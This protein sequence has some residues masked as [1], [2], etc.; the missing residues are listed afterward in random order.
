MALPPASETQISHLGRLWLYLLAALVLIFLVAPVFV[1]VPMSFSDERYLSFPPESYGLR[2]YR[3]YFASLEWT[4][5]T[6]TSFK[7]ALLVTLLA[8]PLGVAAA[9]GLYRSTLKFS[10][11]VSLLLISPLIVPVIII[12]IGVFYLYARLNLVNTVPGIVLAHT[13]LALPFV[14]VTTTSGLQQFDDQLERAAQSLG[15]SRWMA[16]LTV[17]LPQLR[18]SIV[19]GALFAFITSF[20]EVVISVFIAGGE[21]MTLPRRMFSGLRDQVDPTIAAISSML[22]GLSILLLGLAV[23][24]GRNSD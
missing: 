4:Q 6:V 14:M 16:V 2:W 12:A 5:A 23:A 7:V 22:I 18:G 20:D 21:N 11:T 13:I 19:S 1:V 3:N 17:T 24:F 15:A 10:N 9:Y 8:T